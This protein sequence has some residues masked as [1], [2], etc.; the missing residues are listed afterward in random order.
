MNVIAS[1]I[2]I[3]HR[4]FR[5]FMAITLI[6]CLSLGLLPLASAQAEAGVP[7]G[8]NLLANGGFEQATNS[9]PAVWNRWIASGT[10]Q[11]SVDQAVYEEGTRS[12]RIQAE[13]PARSSATQSV[14]VEAGKAYRLSVRVKM[15]N[16]VS[17]DKGVVLRYQFFNSANQKVGADSFA[18]ARKGTSDWEQITHKVTVPEGAVRML[19]ELFLWNA[20]GT[21][22]F[23]E[24]KV[25]KE[26][27]VTDMIASGHPRLLTT[28]SDFA[29]L[30]GRLLT[31]S[32]L[33]G[34]QTILTAKADQILTQPASHYELPDGVRLLSVSRKVLERIYAL[35]MQY[36]LT[37]DSRYAERAWTELAAAGSFQDWNPS[38][39][40]DTAEMT[41]AFAIGYDW[42]YDYW[43]PER[44]TFLREAIIT[45]GFT[46]ALAGYNRPDFW[47]NT[48]NNWNFVVNG[49]IGMGALAL[50]DEPDIKALA[51]DL[52]QRG[53]ASLP[54]ALPQWAP[55]GGWY[56]GPGYWQ[57]S[58]QYIGVY[59]KALQTALGTDF[60]L[61]QSPGLQLNGD[62]PIFMSSP[63]NQIFNFADAG[64]SV[65]NSPSLHW[66]GEQFGKP[67]YG[68]WQTQRV[69]TNPS[70][71][72]LLWYVPNSYTGP[73]AAQ[74][75]LDKYFRNVEA[76]T[77]RSAWEDPNALFVGFKGASEQKNHHNLDA[78]TFLFDALGVRWA[79]E[80][81]A[82]NYNLPGYFGNQRWNY[83]RM[84]GEGQNV[85]VIN[86]G[87]GPEQ[88]S[89]VAIEMSRVESSLKDALAIADLTAA[90]ARDV[91]KAERGVRLLDNRRQMVVQDEVYAKAPSD[92]WW[93]MHT[94]TEVDEIA[95]DGSWAMLTK[96][97]KR[98]WACIL[99]PAQA[100]FTVMDPVPLPTSP[101]PGGQ[102]ANA[103]IRKLAIHIQDV[104]QLSLSVLFVP[105]REG[106]APPVT[107]PPVE[108]LSEW[109]IASS[110]TPLLNGISLDGS[111]L[112]GFDG[113]TF[114]YDVTLPSG[115]SAPP[116]VTASAADPNANVAVHQ[117]SGLP[118][119]ATVDVSLPG[120]GSTR[121]AVYFP[122]RSSAGQAGLPVSAVT[123]SGDDG[124]VPAN[125]IDDDLDTR[126][127]ALGDGQWI[128]FDLGSARTVRS[129]SL[130][131]YRGKER[132]SSFDIDVSAD[133][134]SWTNVYSGSS[135]GLSE[136]LENYGTGDHSARYVRIVGH[137]NS[138]NLFN[139][140]TE[141]RVYDRVA[142][143]QNKPPNLK[144][145]VLAADQTRLKVS[146]TAQLLLSGTMT[147]GG[148][149]D[150]SGAGVEY[151][152]VNPA[153]AAVSGSGVVTAIGEGT[154]KVAAIV[155]L[156]G[157]V[158][159]AALEFEV[160]DP[161]SAKLNP[162]KDTFV[163]NGDYAGS[164]Y[165]GNTSMAVKKSS[166]GFQ[167]EAFLQFD[168]SGIAG[169]VMSASL[170][171]YGATND[172]AGT[173][174]DNTIRAVSDDN[175]T[176]TGLTWNNKPAVQE[177]LSTV[178]VDNTAAWR[179]FD[180]TPY[181][182]AQLAGDKIASVSVVQDVTSGLASNFNSKENAN[183]K[184]YLE[185][186]L[187][188][189]EAPAL[190]VTGVTYN[191]GYAYGA[192]P[193]I[194]ATDAGSG[195]KSLSLQLN[196]QPFASGSSVTALGLHTLSA[197]AVDFAGNAAAQTV[198]F[199]V[200]D[201][202]KGPTTA[203]GWFSA[204]DAGTVTAS[205]YNKIHLVAK[206]GYDNHMLPEGRLSLH[207][208]SSGL[209][210]ELDGLQMLAIDTSG[211]IAQ[212]IARGSDQADYSVRLSIRET[213]AN[214]RPLASLTVLPMG[215]SD[216]IFEATDRPLTGNVNFH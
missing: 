17:S 68:W 145:V 3:T 130:A 134:A 36:R 138:Q 177:S 110:A 27:I 6:F 75:G 74:V 139:S 165:G 53:F 129:V 212:G 137:G 116:V 211:F 171:L 215:I 112:S 117:A 189:S 210:L 158:K 38:H 140:I 204:A 5:R 25:S 57:Y 34:W 175:W 76:V 155:T 163:R 135:S 71:L 147:S 12:L 28:A 33:A 19:F 9:L 73:R 41:H 56:E 104:Q 49:G 48:T 120:G 15:D 106:E 44:R 198:A 14:G 31:D 205:T 80:L 133:G 122:G 193:I 131:W 37:A 111:P 2:R 26:V 132:T 176:E 142:S 183:N 207:F 30:Q 39:F 191:Q 1:W 32:R 40:L 85:L 16:I 90:Y 42:L 160:N 156:G 195:V 8:T 103:G 209:K 88:D 167:R 185:I 95:P 102:N 51:E 91:H 29:A 190:S 126:W 61:S 64:S 108:P 136:E 92:Y 107:L 208:Q 206:L 149:L 109:Q 148:P 97:G 46:P 181:I 214:M 168:L 54:K 173:E 63:I 79:Q 184:P 182:A 188:D 93:F 172:S 199:A 47:V 21:V 18:G 58:I 96:N 4:P 125:T 152:S 84:R 153:V 202:T 105:L 7:E 161:L 150:T 186:K 66:F 194:S 179:K 203:A 50:G 101:S 11:Y 81:G 72:D 166:V 170:Y 22:W 192:T 43:T 151:V 201:P 82:D 100:K 141:A 94:S 59:F 24:A 216:P 157:Y 124:N 99:S 180:I 67:E 154:A 65:P 45:K 123:A 213:A 86:P 23:D 164:N 98:L 144:S 169:D 78:G 35:G 20:S 146:Q 162:V 119:S 89:S 196:G 13:A 69:D 83:Y 70:P 55:D 187:A 197:T 127:S 113:K 128:A 159:I 200:Y 174:V 115:T 143:E 114:T 77:F 121:Y 87:L 118:G 52:L 62:F 10:P 60:G 178:R